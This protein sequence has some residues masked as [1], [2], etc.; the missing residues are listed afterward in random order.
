MARA[1]IKLLLFLITLG[2]VVGC[3][4]TAFWIYQNVMVKEDQIKAGL[5]E[6]KAPGRPPPD[7]GARRFDNA[8][9]LVHE[10]KLQDARDALYKLL[11]QFP[12]SSTCP[13]AKRILGEMNM[14]ALCAVDSAGGKKDY[15]VQKGDNLLGIA[16]RNHTTVE[17]I[18]RF[19]SLSSINLQPG[20]H[21]FLIP[22]DFDLVLNATTGK[23]TLLQ[24]GLF[25]KEYQALQTTLSPG[26]RVPSEM[27]IGGK[28][29]MVAGKSVNPVSR[30]FVSA[31]KTIIAYK[32]ANTVGLVIHSPP[33]PQPVGP[34]TAT[35]P[36]DPPPSAG[37][38]SKSKSK[39]KEKP[40]SPPK[41]KSKGKGKPANADGTPAEDETSAAPSAQTG[42]VL[43]NE[44][45]EEIYPILRKGSKLRI[46]R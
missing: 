3:M 28:S 17:A 21:L 12:K 26:T 36:L 35:T 16:G 1:Q 43:T 24:N 14:D 9:E 10:G 20:E 40:P 39:T 4:A 5:K 32:S 41:A 7:P 6:L 34:T 13:E 38:G 22:V 31:D 37:S 8:I 45:I 33:R 23:L 29:A 2:I 11:L 18:A 19:N 30:D 15:I 27:D 42:L 44:D 46:V 25:F